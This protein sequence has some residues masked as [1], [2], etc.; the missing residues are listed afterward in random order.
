MEK[1]RTVKEINA[2]ILLFE[3]Q[4]ANLREFLFSFILQGR[5]EPMVS[6]PWQPRHCGCKELQL[7]T[8]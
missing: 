1:K 6:A 8:S 4:N 7:L 2:K 5:I 3:H